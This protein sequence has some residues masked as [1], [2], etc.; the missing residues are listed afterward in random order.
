MT[1]KDILHAR[2]VSQRQ[3]A[4]ALATSPATINLIVNKGQWPRT[5]AQELRGRMIHWLRSLGVAPAKATTAVLGTG[6]RDVSAKGKQSD[7]PP[8][9]G[10]GKKE[11][12]MIRKQTISPKARRAFGIT[13]DPFACDIRADDL[14]LSRD[15]RFVRESMLQ[16]ARH[17]GLLA[18]IGQSGSGKSTLRREVVN[19]LEEEGK[20][21]VIEPYVLGLEDN[22]KT[23]KTMKSLHIAEA[24]LNTV[25]PAQKCQSSPEARFRQIHKVLQDSHAAGNRHV[26]LI[27]EAHS[28]PFPTIKHLKRFYEL[29][30]GYSKLLAIILIGQN[31][32]ADKLSESNAEVREVVQRCEVVELAPL[33]DVQ[34]Y[35]AHRCKQ[36]GLDAAALFD[37]AVFDALPAILRGPAAQNGAGESLLYP[38]AVGNM[39]TLALNAAAYAG[40]SRVTADI[41]MSL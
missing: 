4:E 15:L 34:G 23:G 33:Q 28:L 20:T 12:T 10:P 30:K 41:I 11:K 22:D 7:N 3:A 39:L 26:L 17:G 36:V 37:G 29:E 18:V 35:V 32:L 6:G 40:E 2:R 24:I 25:A 5:G 13:R 1:L 21:I 14:Y 8:G 27:E 16:T 19:A 38:L 9:R 31:E